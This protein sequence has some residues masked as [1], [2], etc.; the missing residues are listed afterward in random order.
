MK[1]LIA[2]ISTYL[3]LARAIATVCALATACAAASDMPAGDFWVKLPERTI[4]FPKESIGG[5]A[6][7][8]PQKVAADFDTVIES[9]GKAQGVVH[10]PAGKV[11]KFAPFYEPSEKYKKL[12]SLKPDDIDIIDVSG[13]EFK[14]DDLKYLSKLTGVCELDVSDTEFGDAGAKW[15]SQMTG[16]RVVVIQTTNLTYDGLNSLTHLPNLK[17]LRLAQNSALDDRCAKLLPHFKTVINLDIAMTRIKDTGLHDIIAGM[18][19]LMRLNCDCLRVTDTSVE[20]VGALPHLKILGLANSKISDGCI[21]TLKKAKGLTELDIRSTKITAK[22]A[23]EL[24]KALPRCNVR[25]GE[26]D[27]GNF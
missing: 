3:P 10:K 17:V 4:V 11:L 13:G 25:T 1:K 22:G 5:Y 2:F 23:A 21:P 15:I 18:P 14:N 19:Q 20:A 9:K 16:L 26:A 24:Q 12:S 27:R 7:T 8:H 6:I